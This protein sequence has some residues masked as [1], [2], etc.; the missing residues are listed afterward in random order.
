MLSDLPY[1]GFI[2]TGKAGTSLAIALARAGYPITAVY[3][4]DP[5]H[6]RAVV[7]RTGAALCAA[8]EDVAQLSELIFLTVPDDVVR[9]VA[10]QI[11][12]SGGFRP[13]SAV[14]HTSGTVGGD[15]LA[16]ITGPEVTTGVFHPLQALA[17]ESSVSLL[18]GAFIGLQAGEEL[19]P[20]L[21]DM[22]TRLGA[23]PIDLTNVSRV[24]Y[25]IAAVL[26]SN[27]TVALLAAARKLMVEAG[28]HE[29]QALP[30]LV[31]LARGSLFNLEHR[32]A[33]SG[34]TGPVVRGDVG[35]ISEHM[36][37]LRQT[38]PELAEMYS[39]LAKTIL[40]LLGETPNHDLILEEIGH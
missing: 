33:A 39:T 1:L 6:T 27:Y 12:T 10:E 26:A 11:A 34:I 32:G 13:G 25:H 17:G 16:E 2:G 5:E 8:P 20:V 14:V 28:L 3:A 40:D 36:E 23:V 31:Q 4:R 21:K 22:V 19:W 18:T 24:P 9:D 38:H 7:D 29:D 30:A 15:V 37:Y 35:T